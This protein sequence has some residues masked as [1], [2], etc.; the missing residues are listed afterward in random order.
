MY[1][2]VPIAMPSCGAHATRS[3]ARDAE[4]GEQRVAGSG[5]EDVLGLHITV[6]DALVVRRL[7][8]VGHLA[9]ELQRVGH[10]EATLS[11]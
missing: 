1:A 10:R 4:V 6:D 3:A 5:E 8:R 9:G 7:Q 11:R 2:A